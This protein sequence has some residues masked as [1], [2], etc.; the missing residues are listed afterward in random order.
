MNK[1]REDQHMES[2]WTVQIEPEIDKFLQKHKILF[3]RISDCTGKE[4]QPRTLKAMSSSRLKQ[5]ISK[6]QLTVYLNSIHTC[7]NQPLEQPN[8]SESCH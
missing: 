2:L 5:D 1:R 7:N 4:K 6:E 8:R 3:M